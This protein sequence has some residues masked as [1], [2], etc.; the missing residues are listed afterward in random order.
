MTEIVS[1]YV[2]NRNSIPINPGVYIYRDRFNKIIYI[3][4]AKNLRSRVSNYFT[5]DHIHSA[6]TRILVSNIFDVE[7]F[8]VDNEVES[9]I[10]ENKLIK[11]HKPKYNILLKDSKT[12]PYIKLSVDK[13]PKLMLTRRTSGRGELFGPFVDSAV[14]NDIFNLTISLFGLITDKTYSTKSSLNYDIGLAPARSLSEIDVDSYMERVDLARDFLKGRNITAVKRKLKDEMAVC[15]S[16]MK[17]EQALIKKKQLHSIE[18]LLEKQKIDLVKNYDQDVISMVVD[19]VNSKNVFV[20]LNISKGVISSK[21]EFKFDLDNIEDTFTSFVKMYYS[22]A[23]VPREILVSHSFWKDENEL[24][25]LEEYLSGLSGRKVVINCPQRG[26]KK[27]LVELG[28]SNAKLNVGKKNVLFEVKE[29][30]GLKNLP[31]VIEVFDMS[32]LSYDFLVGGMT[33]WVDEKPDKSGYRKFDI[34]SFSGKNDD[35]AS[36]EECVYRRY[37]RLINENKPL[38]DLILIDGGLGQFS[39]SRKVLKD[40]GILDKVDLISIGKGAERKKNDIY[41]LKSK[42]PLVFDNDL[43][44]MLFLRKVRDSVHNFVISHNRKKRTKKLEREFK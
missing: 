33:R 29:K 26:E 14:R 36:M 7:F 35:F 20:L 41:T 42:E 23:Y 3:G 32:N 12:Y 40:L 31:K 9:L 10:L 8:I 4:K 28:I 17:F 11:K 24:E 27:S 25:L 37:S 18:I 34:K 5:S 39:V 38:P 44:F 2:F 21:S 6:K 22:Q 1:K 19:E 16:E 13:I 15:S 43:K 30:L